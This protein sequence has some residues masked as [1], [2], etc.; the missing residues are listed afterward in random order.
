[1]TTILVFANDK[2]QSQAI[3]QT[4][5][6][7]AQERGLVIS[8]GSQAPDYIISIG[9]DGTL[10]SAFHHYERFI[11]QSQFIGIHTGHLGFYADWLGEE[12]NQVLESILDAETQTD[13][14][15]YPL[16]EIVIRFKGDSQKRFL[17]LNEF[18]I[19][20]K[21]GTVVC[22]V[23]LR[24]YKFETFRGDGVCI[25][26]PTGS[27]GL[28]KSLG[29]AVIHPSVEAMQMSEM[30]SLNNVVYRTLSSPIIVPKEEWITLKPVQVDHHFFMSIDNIVLE[31]QKIDSIRLQIAPERIHFSSCR[32]LDFWDRVESSFIGR[33]DFPYNE[34]ERVIK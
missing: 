28:N 23:Y 21:N 5:I 2:H 24:D 25:S 10:L 27:T 32:H 11:N 12:V 16:L 14:V 18:A 4:L 1:M 15:S 3:Q 13:S 30:A 8:D 17:A 34:V 31:G 7:K 26:T 19:R 22:D 20:S 6:C 9:G 33:R 29:G